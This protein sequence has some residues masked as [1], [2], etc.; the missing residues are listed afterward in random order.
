M[1]VEAEH[2]V[3]GRDVSGMMPANNTNYEQL[4]G[5][6][7]VYNGKKSAVVALTP[8]L[9]PGPG[10]TAYALQDALSNAGKVLLKVAGD[11]PA[12]PVY[13]KNRDHEW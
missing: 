5:L 2:R 4:D 3:L 6:T 11:P 10:L 8:F 12:P 7:S 9:A 1:G 13:P